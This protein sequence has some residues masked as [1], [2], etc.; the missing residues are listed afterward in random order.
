[1]IDLTIALTWSIG[2]TELTS[3]SCIAQNACLWMKNGWLW[4]LSWFVIEESRDAK[5]SLAYLMMLIEY[6]R[7]IKYIHFTGCFMRYIWISFNLSTNISS[8]I[9]VFE[10]YYDIA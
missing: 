4:L 9:V 2:L 1:M 8:I 6:N 10:L 5:D 7:C 3:S